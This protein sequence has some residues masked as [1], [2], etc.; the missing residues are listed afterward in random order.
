[1][2]AF[3]VLGLISS[4]TRLVTSMLIASGCEGGVGYE[5]PWDDKLPYDQPLIVWR[6]SVP[7]KDSDGPTPAIRWM[8]RQLKDRGYETTIILITHEDKDPQDYSYI[9][10]QIGESTKYVEVSSE[11]LL[12]NR[13]KV[14]KDLFARLDL[15]VPEVVDIYGD[16]DDADSSIHA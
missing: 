4:E 1:M 3:V 7:D 13:D 16:N 12:L 8:L 5:Q 15:D 9:Y 6:R 2:R 11:E 14:I 10:S